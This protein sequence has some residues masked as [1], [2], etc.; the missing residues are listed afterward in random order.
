[1]G[2]GHGKTATRGS[3][4]Q[5]SRAGS[6]TRPGFEGG[7][8]PLHR[9]LPKRGFTNIFKKRFAV[10]NLRDL[11]DFTAAETV[12]PQLLTSRGLVK[13]LG[14]GLRILGDGDLKAPLK[15][16]A[17]HFSKSALEKI[18]KAGGTAEVISA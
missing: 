13:K 4:G 3:K 2:S 17:H 5:R 6:R 9:R 10:I 15:I 11:K 8:M 12:T 1:M 16:S 18:K 14:D 7:Q